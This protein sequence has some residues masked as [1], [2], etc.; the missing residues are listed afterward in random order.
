VTLA[1]YVR[2]LRVRW[3][4]WL[5]CVLLGVA[6]AAMFS[7]AAPVKYTATATSFVLV[8]AVDPTSPDNFQNSQFAVQRVK[9]Y[10]PLIES[11]DVL[12]PVID[13]L[14]LTLTPRE[15]REL[16]TITSPPET[17]LLEVHVTDTNAQLSALI[18]DA[19]SRR[20]GELIEELEAPQTVTTDP[21]Q[22]GA[23]VTAPVK[24]TLTRPAEVP[25][26]PSSPRWALNLVL[27]LAAGLAVGF[28]AALARHALDRRIKSGDDIRAITGTAPLGAT[29]RKRPSGGEPLIVLNHRTAGA[30]SYRTIR[31]ALKFASVDRAL[32]HLVISSPRAGE[33]K[34]TVAAN[35]AVSWAQG[36]GKVCLVEA[37]LRRPGVSPLLGLDG[38]VGLTEVLVGEAE[39]DDVLVP[40][41][42][43]LITVLP[44]GSLPPDPAALLGSDSMAALVA[45]LHERFDM[46]IYDTAPVGLVTDAAV[47]GRA[48]DGVVLVVQAGVSSRD[49]LAAAV[50]ML[51]SS[52]VPVLGTVLGSLKGRARQEQHYTSIDHS[53]RRGRK[54]RQAQGQPLVPLD[55]RPA[56]VVGSDDD[57]V[58]GTA[59]A[60]SPATAGSAATPDGSVQLTGVDHVDHVDGGGTGPGATR[61]DLADGADGTERPNG[62]T[63]KADTAGKIHVIAK[64]NGAGKVNGMPKAKRI[65]KANGAS[66]IDGSGTD[67]TGRP[68]PR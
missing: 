34:T 38:S 46:V 54:S 32:G 15:L 52:R 68:G 64:A 31:S 2:V 19:V 39:L 63:T 27:G 20:L 14:D 55:P 47:L 57:T 22:L 45:Q 56:G 6:A 43:G 8:T 36:G 21:D 18:A 67:P 30:E 50:E 11:P 3:R 7:F 35:L 40:W 1:D 17:V 29:P 48:V 66:R 9:S 65:T 42:N 12:V 41:R 13:D 58:A 10:A 61:P 60:G 5:A 28:M 62:T 49:P 25:A 44:A 24:V 4:I 51:R 53:S 23:P 59:T 33:G 37:D 16:I 26:A